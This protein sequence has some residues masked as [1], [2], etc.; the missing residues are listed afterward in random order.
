MV[1]DAVRHAP[2]TFSSAD[3]VADA[4]DDDDTAAS[5]GARV[6]RDVHNITKVSTTRAASVVDVVSACW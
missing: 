6:L 5:L 3:A 4:S 2:S 1:F